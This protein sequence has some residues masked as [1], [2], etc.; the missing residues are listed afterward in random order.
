MV[1][2]KLI[3]GLGN[4][5]P[6]YRDHR[7]NV[8]FMVVDELARRRGLVWGGDDRRG[9]EAVDTRGGLVLLKPLTYMNLSGDAVLAWSLREFPDG[10]APR[11][12]VV[13]D[14][15]ALPLGSLRLR[16]RGSSGGQNGLESIIEALEG[17]DVPRLR[18]GIAPLA[19]EVDPARWADFVLKPFAPDEREAARSVVEHAA[20]AV[21]H[22][23]E[24]GLE[25]TVSRFNRRVKRP[26]PE[27]P[28]PD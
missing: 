19:G 27:E 15:L 25:D 16:G 6:G 5:G 20:D 1:I 9:L 7:H 14:D 11:P 10:G 4:P 28:G 26:E 17:A 23:L 8:G 13:C 21:E 2:R 24:A 18:L 3:V 22:W 12:L